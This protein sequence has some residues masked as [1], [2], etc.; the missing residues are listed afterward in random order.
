MTRLAV[1]LR[2][3]MNSE[4][5]K[6]HA[7]YSNAIRD[8]ASSYIANIP[9]EAKIKAIRDRRVYLKN[10]VTVKTT[11]GKAFDFSSIM[12]T[13]KVDE[14]ARLK[15]RANLNE[16]VR[17]LK[18]S[19]CFDDIDDIKKQFNMFEKEV[20]EFVEKGKKRIEKLNALK[21]AKSKRSCLAKY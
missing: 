8:V 17:K 3:I 18:Y 10:D 11:I 6:L 16:K 15:H 14:K 7:A 21:K 2:Q 9:D 5:D 20:R 4:V 19:V 13:I 1:G 12:Y